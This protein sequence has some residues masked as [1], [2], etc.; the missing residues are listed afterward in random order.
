[1]NKS[2]CERCRHTDC[3]STTHKIEGD[4][5]TITET[6]SHCTGVTTT[7]Y[8]IYVIFKQTVYQ[9]QKNIVGF[10]PLDDEHHEPNEHH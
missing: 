8:N 1:M 3:V 9:N 2:N 4:R 6:C 7:K 10:I 5:M